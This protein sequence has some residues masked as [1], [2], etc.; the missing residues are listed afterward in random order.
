MRKPKQVTVSPDPKTD[1]PEA[2]QVTPEYEE[3]LTRPG[4]LSPEPGLFDKGPL[5]SLEVLCRYLNISTRTGRRLL[6]SGVLPVY[7]IGNQIRVL[8]DD[9]EKYV[10][11][12]LIPAAEVGK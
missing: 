6:A 8:P 11:A 3:W 7:R 10:K 2:R 1:S 9:V 12:S 4:P 5:L